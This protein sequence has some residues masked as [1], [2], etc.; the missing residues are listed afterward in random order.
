MPKLNKT[1]QLQIITLKDVNGVI[2]TKEVLPLILPPLTIEFVIERNPYAGASSADI[3]V[4]NLSENTRSKI[5]QDIYV[6]PQENVLLYGGYESEDPSL[7][8]DLCRV[9]YLCSFYPA[10][11]GDHYR[12]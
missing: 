3:K 4:Y 9:R 10:Q 6:A 1:F 8:F 2:E 5:F 12:A 7:F 11:N